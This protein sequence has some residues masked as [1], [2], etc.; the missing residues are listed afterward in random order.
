MKLIEPQH[1]DTIAKQSAPRSVT[2]WMPTHPAGADNRQ[3][4]IRLKNL[5]NQAEEQLSQLGV[6]EGEAKKR[7]KPL[8]DTVDDLEFWR[9]QSESLGVFVGDDAPMALRLPLPSDPLVTVSDH[10]HLKPLFTPACDNESFY[11]LKLSEQTV[12][13]IRANRLSA[14]VVDLPDAPK[15][16]RYFMRFD[17]PERQVEFHSGSA[18]HGPDGNR[19]GVFHGQGTAGDKATEKKHL[20]EYCREISHALK[21]KLYQAPGPLL[22]A[23]TEPLNGIFHQVCTLQQLDERH[24]D[25]NPD[26]ASAQ[27]L[28][29][30]AV[31]LLREDFHKA[32]D[33]ATD[34]YWQAD[35]RNLAGND[36]H[37][38]LRAATLGA[39][40][41]LLVSF[42][43]HKW[44]RYD[45]ER[46]E[47]TMHETDHQPGDDDLLNLAAVLAYRSGA[48]VHAVQQDD[49]PTDAP[50]AAVLRFR[51]D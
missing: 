29:T 45:P 15:S 34:R 11:I 6:A 24:L 7:L 23:A 27:D 38:I 14:E 46:N 35:H 50:V 26:R 8:R 49:L 13:L 31:E 47:L 36:L 4:P 18:D 43:E 41:S 21:K 17:D 28:Q 48:K 30:R 33:E 39:V 37:E 51:E 2:I 25:G 16:F 44:G 40:D 5:V 10:F 19:P 1:L 12:E 42:D 22:V 3:D 9:N 20:V 32:I